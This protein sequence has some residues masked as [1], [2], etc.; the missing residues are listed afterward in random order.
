M[1]TVVDFSPSFC[2][3]NTMGNNTTWAIFRREL[4]GVGKIDSLWVANM[5]EKL[6]CEEFMFDHPYLLRLQLFI[7]CLIAKNET[8]RRVVIERCGSSTK[9]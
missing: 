3:V 8:V 4:N 2:L 6:Y 5:L 1:H 7:K 9:R